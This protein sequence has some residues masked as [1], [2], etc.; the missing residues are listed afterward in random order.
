[1]K[2]KK[3]LNPKVIERKILKYSNEKI[4]KEKAQK[5]FYENKLKRLYSQ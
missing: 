1:M 2:K 3:K 5:K 4:K